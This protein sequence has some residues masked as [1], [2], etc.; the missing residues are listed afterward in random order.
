MPTP[1]QGARHLS[2]VIFRIGF[3]NVHFY[4]RP[5]QPSLLWLYQRVDKFPTLTFF[6]DHNDS[7]MQQ[8]FMY[9]LVYIYKF[10][11]FSF[12]SGKLVLP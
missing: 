4:I 2:I 10:Y 5:S 3:S 6:D 7:L 9:I 12:C 8:L 11:I 1:Y